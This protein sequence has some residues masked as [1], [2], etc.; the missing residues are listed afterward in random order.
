VHELDRDAGAHELGDAAEELAIERLVGVV[1]ADP[2]FEQIAE[3]VERG[4]PARLLVEEAEE[5]RDDRR[6]LGREVQIRDE[7][8]RPRAGF[9]RAQPVISARSITTSSSGTSACTP[10]R[11]VFTPLIRST[12]S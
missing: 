6:T 2:V 7:Q 12:T 5:A 8:D 9:G 1:V 10:R 11:P 3:D 4:G